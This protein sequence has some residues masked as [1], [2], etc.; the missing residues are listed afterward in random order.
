M[1]TLAVKAFGYMGQT[2]RLR[3]IRDRSIAGHD[4]C[5]LRQHLDSVSP[6][7]PI[8]DIVDRC[9]LW[10]SHADSDTRRFSQPGPDRTLPIYTVDALREAVDDR[11]VA[12]VTTTQPEPDWLETLLRRLLSGLA[13]PSLPPE[14]A[15]LPL[16]QLLQ[17]LLTEAQAPLPTPPAQHCRVP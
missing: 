12:A 14:P 6:E 3:I 5:E 11:V 8:R 2:A 4:S 9:R 16:E 15:P 17:S 7:T 10:E 1:E 13:V